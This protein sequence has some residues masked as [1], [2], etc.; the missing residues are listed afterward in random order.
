MKDASPAQLDWLRFVQG[1]LAEDDT[2][3][4]EACAEG[5]PPKC[6]TVSRADQ[7]QCLA[8]L[9]DASPAQDDSSTG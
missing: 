5:P 7:W 4:D 9:K 2:P 8:R 1:Y 6:L 3:L